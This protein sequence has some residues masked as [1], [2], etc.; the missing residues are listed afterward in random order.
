M[1]QTLSKV[2]GNPSL[3]LFLNLFFF[4]LVLWVKQWAKALYSG[5]TKIT[6]RYVFL[7]P[8]LI[9]SPECSLQD[10]LSQYSYNQTQ[11]LLLFLFWPFIPSPPNCPAGQTRSCGPISKAIIVIYRLIYLLNCVLF[12]ITLIPCAENPSECAAGTAEGWGLTPGKSLRHGHD[13]GLRRKGIV[14]LQFNT[15]NH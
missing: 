7:S 15:G 9:S 12:Y 8:Y 1:L 11:L 3:F 2:A 4:L 6:N 14:L 10:N 5:Y 13:Q